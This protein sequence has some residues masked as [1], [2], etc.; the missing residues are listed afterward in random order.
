MARSRGGERLDGG[1]VAAP[2]CINKEIEI[3]LGISHARDLSASRLHL[4]SRAQHRTVHAVVR[5]GRV[6]AR[7]F[8]LTSD[9][10]YTQK[11]VPYVRPNSHLTLR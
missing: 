9:L 1:A 8:N 11:S 6:R 7:R 5:S 3:G 10:T 4:S 2:G